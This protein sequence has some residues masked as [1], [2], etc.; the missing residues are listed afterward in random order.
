[1]AEQDVEI[2]VR[3]N[4]KQARSELRDLNKAAAGT[5]QQ[6]GGGGRGRGPGFGAAAAGGLGAV[7]GFAAGHLKSAG[8]GIIDDLTR[9]PLVALER[10]ILNFFGADPD[11][12]LKGQAQA[13]AR[14]GMPNRLIGAQKTE[15]GRERVKSAAYPS[16]LINTARNLETLKGARSV[17]TDTKF[18]GIG[19]P[20]PTTPPRVKTRE[21]IEENMR[22]GIDGPF[23]KSTDRIIQELRKSGGGKK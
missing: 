3:L 8:G 1:M 7:V 2:R 23:R 16:F 6:V 17:A 9:G 10:W 22:R 4:T 13:S 14:R 18:G 19:V 20:R 15:A 11:A 21:E 12:S 5:A